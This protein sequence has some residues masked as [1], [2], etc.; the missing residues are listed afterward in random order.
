M[1]K[2]QLKNNDL[3]EILRPYDNMWVALSKDNKKVIE[4]G[5]SLKQ[6]FEKLKGKDYRE[7]EFM[8]VPDFRMSYAPYI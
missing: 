1:A 4:A 3:S 8:K 5:K 7:F 2:Q 6:L